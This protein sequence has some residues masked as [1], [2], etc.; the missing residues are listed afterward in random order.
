MLQTLRDIYDT[1]SLPSGEY[2]PID[3]S[4]L[5]AYSDTSYTLPDFPDFAKSLKTCYQLRL[6][7]I[8]LLYFSPVTELTRF[9]I[10]RL[11]RCVSR[12]YVL[13]RAHHVEATPFE[14]YIAPHT[15]QR[16]FPEHGSLVQPKH[17]NGAFTYVRAGATPSTPTLTPAP[18]P[19]LAPALAPGQSSDPVPVKIYIF[20]KEEFPKVMLHEICHHLPYH[21]PPA[22]WQPDVLGEFYRFFSIDA[23]GCPNQCRVRLEPNEAIVEFWATIFHL[24]FLSIE[25]KNPQRFPAL[26]ACEKQW[27]AQQSHL[28]LERQRSS[29]GGRWVEDTHSYAYIVLKNILLQHAEDFMAN[30]QPPYDPRAL[31]NFFKTRAESPGRSIPK[32]ASSARRSRCARSMRMTALGDM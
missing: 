31:L 27:S 3:P 4:I 18:A 22:K 14:I 25:S 30:Q 15:E 24:M 28:L 19:A 17:I 6:E 9:E 29:P 5:G 12:A 16:A 32:N 11:R 23:L 21:T 2:V 13:V 1:L 8:R 7:N 10:L 26:L 20:R